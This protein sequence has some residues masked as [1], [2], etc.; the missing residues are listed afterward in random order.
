MICKNGKVKIYYLY[1]RKIIMKLWLH[2]QITVFKYIYNIMK[3]IDIDTR[4]RFQ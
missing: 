3:V 4:T 1:I 2:V